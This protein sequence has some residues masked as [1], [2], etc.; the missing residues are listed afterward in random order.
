M[1]TFNELKTTN[2]KSIKLDNHKKV[3]I[4]TLEDGMVITRSTSKEGVPTLE[5]QDKSMKKIKMTKF[6]C[7]LITKEEKD[8]VGE[9]STIL[10]KW[11]QWQPLEQMTGRYY[12]KSYNDNFENLT[13]ILSKYDVKNDTE[14]H[15]S[16][17]NGDE[18]YRKINESY[19]LRLW[20]YLDET[21]KDLDRRKSLFKVKDSEY[22]KFLSEESGSITDYL[23]F[24]HYCIMD[25]EWS[26]DIATQ[27]VPKVELFVDGNLVESSEFKLS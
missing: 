27:R 16:F 11:Q 21:H 26:F 22:L 23:H 6:R 24:E 1:K 9:V 20:I 15:I 10:G 19:R 12:I 13:F 4:E 18:I 2:K 3:M 5:I 25:N 14:V 7:T 17:E 8:K